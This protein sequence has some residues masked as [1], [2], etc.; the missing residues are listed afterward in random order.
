MEASVDL[1]DDEKRFLERQGITP[2]QVLDARGMPK[3]IWRARARAEGK[4]AVIGSACREAGHRLRSRSGHCIQ[5][6]P[7]VLAYQARFSEHG[8]IY[9]AYSRSTGLV[10]IGGSAS[11]EQREKSLIGYAGID[12][13]KILNSTRVE[14]Y[15]QVEEAVR[16]KLKASLKPL[17]YWREGRNQIASEVY[18]CS[19]EE[20]TKALGLVLFVSCPRIFWTP[21]CP[22][23]GIHDEVEHDPNR[24]QR[25]E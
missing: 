5:C 4:L 10:K 11:A 19:I 25:C 8:V 24:N 23:G 22:T 21:I 7:S 3:A 17:A 1:T 20:A 13:W 9:I 2:A 15:G 14:G 6:D 16:A 18:A 12:D